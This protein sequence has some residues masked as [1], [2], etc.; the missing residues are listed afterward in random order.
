[1]FANREYF[2]REH[3]TS[4]PTLQSIEK[5]LDETNKKVDNLAAEFQKQNDQMQAQS[6]QA[7]AAK[8]SL[9]AINTGYNN[10]IPVR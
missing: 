6:Q 10:V 7:A 4:K 9:D 8:A 5:K 2:V 3:L 1:M